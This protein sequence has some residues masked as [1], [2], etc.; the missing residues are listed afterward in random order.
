ML[1]MGSHALFAQAGLKP[2]FSK[3]QPPR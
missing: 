2:G 1:E 3:S